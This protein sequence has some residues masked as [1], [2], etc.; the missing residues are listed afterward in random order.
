VIWKCVFLSQTPKMPFNYNKFIRSLK[1]IPPPPPPPSLRLWAIRLGL[2]VSLAGVVASLIL[3]GV[4]LNLAFKVE[5]QSLKIDSMGTLID[6]IAAQNRTL[7]RISEQNSS[8]IASLDSIYG[9][10]RINTEPKLKVDIGQTKPI[11]DTINEFSLG[12]TNTGSRNAEH[13]S[14]EL[15]KVYDSLGT[16]KAYT[17]FVPD[18][19]LTITPGEQAFEE[20][21][22]FHNKSYELKNWRVRITFR[23][24]DK[25]QRIPTTQPFYFQPIWENDQVLSFEY[26]PPPYRKK[27]DSAINT[28]IRQKKATL[29][30]KS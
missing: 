13:L 19:N 7:G 4:S 11:N 27:M 30:K 14:T 15:F 29:F 10:E 24:Q 26:C 12:I 21:K 6:S 18:K 3:G 1:S 20:V 16:L 8:L 9:A 22:F 28:F 23:Y 2:W 5:G 17:T 25:L